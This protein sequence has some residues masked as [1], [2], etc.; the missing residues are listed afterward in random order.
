MFSHAFSA[1]LSP[2]RRV[3]LCRTLIIVTGWSSSLHIPAIISTHL[4]TVRFM[5][6]GQDGRREIRVCQDP[7]ESF[8]LEKRLCLRREEAHCLKT[9][10]RRKWNIDTL[11]LQ[12]RLYQDL[13]ALKRS[14]RS[15]TSRSETKDVLQEVQCEEDPEGYLVPD[16]HHCN[17]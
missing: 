12:I 16:P 1:S 7:E 2:S 6:C 14:T 13:K 3:T 15:I 9:G 11:G 4:S 10:R 8:H 17:R 5:V